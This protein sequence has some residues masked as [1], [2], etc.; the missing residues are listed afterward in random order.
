MTIFLPFEPLGCSR[1]CAKCCKRQRGVNTIRGSPL[2]SGKSLLLHRL[3]RPQVIWLFRQ[4]ASLTFQSLLACVSG[5]RPPSP[6][7]S[8][9]FQET[10]SDHFSLPCKRGLSARLCA[11]IPSAPDPRGAL[12]SS[13]VFIPLGV[14][15]IALGTRTPGVWK[16]HTIS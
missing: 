7:R 10:S 12:F 9:F 5:K 4:Q 6:L 8:Y 1:H 15:V 13:V 2:F 14:T 11:F 3:K 16:A